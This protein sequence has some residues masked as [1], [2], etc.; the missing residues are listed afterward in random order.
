[1]IRRLYAMLYPV[2]ASRG[3]LDIHEG[4]FFRK[5]RLF[6]QEVDYVLPYGHQFT[7]HPLSNPT[8]NGRLT[9]V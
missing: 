3:I 8:K 5:N 9:S 2:R 7:I 4:C 1:M 6:P